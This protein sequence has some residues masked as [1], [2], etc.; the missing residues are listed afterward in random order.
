MEMEEDVS[1]IR[2]DSNGGAHPS[3]YTWCP[4]DPLALAHFLHLRSPSTLSD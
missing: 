1:I 4:L 2:V 3:V